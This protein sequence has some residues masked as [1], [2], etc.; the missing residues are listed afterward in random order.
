MVF[1][2]IF[3]KYIS[4]SLWAKNIANRTEAFQIAIDSNIFTSALKLR[5]LMT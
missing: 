1:R 5:N 2:T 3:I 4:L